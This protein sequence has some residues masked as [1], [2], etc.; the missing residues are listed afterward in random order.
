M[1]KEIQEMLKK[2]EGVNRL[3]APSVRNDNGGWNFLAEPMFEYVND[4]IDFY[5]EENV[6]MSRFNPATKGSQKTTNHEGAVAYK[7]SPELEL[8]SLV[9]TCLCQPKFYESDKEQL[10][11]LRTLIFQCHPEFVFK[12]AVYARKEMHL[13]SI[14]VVLLVEFANVRRISSSH[15]AFMPFSD[16][17]YEV[18]QR[19]DDMT[20]LLAYYQYVNKDNWHGAKKLCK[21][22]NQIKLGLKRAFSKFDEYQI[23]KYNRSGEVTLRDVMF[24]THPERTEVTDKLT[25]GVLKTPYTWETELSEKGNVK[26][27]WEP[28]INSGKVGYM[29][30]LRNLRNI[31]NA[32]VRQD[33]IAT[34]ATRLSDKNAVLKS[35][36]FPFRFLSAYKQITPS[37]S[38]AT[39][40]ALNALEDAMIHS[41]ENVKGFGYE[42]KVVI[43]ADVSGSMSHPISKNSTVMYHDVGLCLAMLLHNRCKSVISGIFGTDWKVINLPQRSILSNVC[44]LSG[45]NGNVGHGTNGYKVIDHLIRSKSVADKVM[46]FTD[47][48]MWDTSGRNYLFANCWGEYKKFIA[49]NAKLYLFDLAGYGNTPVSV[50]DKD[51]FLIAG[52]SDKVFDMLDAIEN[53]ESIVEKIKECK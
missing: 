26:E 23:A 22:S 28:L 21:L 12:L 53:G 37:K 20:E 27:V 1:D 43:G 3:P 45:R 36:Q 6:I 16:V 8:Y 29:A 18:I 51:V 9:A 33:H 19:P 40:A 44:E 38:F 32:G 24:L 10:E 52:W 14:S 11:R 46:I 48:Q 34:V 50:R 7:V 39:T 47:C 35:K 4:K 41:A 31:L 49:P 5:N 25:K 17:V 13:R 30:L 42:T 2:V 15:S